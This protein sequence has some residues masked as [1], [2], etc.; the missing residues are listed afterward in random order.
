MDDRHAVQAHAR[1]YVRGRESRGAP[2]PRDS[3]VCG[4]RI[5][6]CERRTIA[7]ATGRMDSDL[8]GGTMIRVTLVFMGA[9]ALAVI[10]NAAEHA[11]IQVALQLLLMALLGCV[12][13]V[14]Y[15]L[16]RTR[17]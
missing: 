3:W 10:A 1:G 15:T 11:T 8:W 12:A 4:L 9:S 6:I 2:A 14:L 13:G 7:G 17:E 16:D 5:Y